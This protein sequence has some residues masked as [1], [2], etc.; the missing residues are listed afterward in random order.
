ANG[1]PGVKSALRTPPTE[2]AKAR[3]RGQAS[4]SSSA[5]RKPMAAP[6]LP[7][8]GSE[9]YVPL[10]AAQIRVRLQER[11]QSLGSMSRM[12]NAVFMGRRLPVVHATT[13]LRAHPLRFA[14]LSIERIRVWT[15]SAPEET[16]E[17]Q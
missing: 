17:R 3:R 5:A 11:Q 9:N 15:E 14:R 8:V 16:G 6:T 2:M 1:P 10:C 12:T 7:T 4:C 13:G